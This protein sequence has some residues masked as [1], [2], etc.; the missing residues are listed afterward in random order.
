MNETALWDTLERYL[1]AEGLE[2]DDVEWLG[3]ILR[4]TVDTEGG[5]DV[6][7]ISETTAGISRLL[8][9]TPE[10]T[11]PYTLEVSSPGLERTLRRPSHFRK[12]VGRE[13]AIKTKADIE[14]ARLHRG[15]LESA[16]DDTCVVGVE[17]GSRSIPVDE[18]VSAKTVFRWERSAKP[19]R[20][21]ASR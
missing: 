16:D 5:I 1:A 7:R 9:G 4:V 3:R 20:K 19:G 13:V 21:E 10:L 17:G 18:I 15:M 14:G 11:G 2:L 8:D 6:G 12:S